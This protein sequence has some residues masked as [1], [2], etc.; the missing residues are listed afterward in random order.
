MQYEIIW[1]PSLDYLVNG[2][3]VSNA[4]YYTER[5]EKSDS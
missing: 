1:K 3:E 2:E 5:E 4:V